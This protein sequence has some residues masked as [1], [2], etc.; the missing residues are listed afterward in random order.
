MCPTKTKQDPHVCES[1]YAETAT[2]D[3]KLNFHGLMGEVS[4][5]IFILRENA[6]FSFLLKGKI[7]V[8]ERL[9]P[10]AW[11]VFL[12]LHFKGLALACFHALFYPA[13]AWFSRFALKGLRVNQEIFSSGKGEGCC[14]SQDDFLGGDGCGGRAVCSS[15]DLTPLAREA[16]SPSLGGQAQ[17]HPIYVWDTHT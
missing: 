11:T 13:R 5:D 14:A 8:M 10:F 7:L 17:L 4:I 16:A 15:G 1:I 9:K 12:E 6:Q 3:N 2:K